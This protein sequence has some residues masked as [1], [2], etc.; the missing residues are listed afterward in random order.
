[1]KSHIHK[2]HYK[3]IVPVRKTKFTILIA[4]GLLFAATTTQAQG[5][6]FHQ[7]VDAR[8]ARTDIRHDRHDIRMDRR[9][10]RL[11]HRDIRYNHRDLRFDRRCW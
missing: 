9:D 4:V 3:S 1:M 5:T 2:H 8:F 10:I 11:D 6:D 7:R